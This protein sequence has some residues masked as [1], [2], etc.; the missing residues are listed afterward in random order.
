MPELSTTFDDAA[1]LV[2]DWLEVSWALEFNGGSFG[3]W[4]GDNS[5]L[6]ALGSFVLRT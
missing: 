3:G 1:P 5:T 4:R 2:L 6:C